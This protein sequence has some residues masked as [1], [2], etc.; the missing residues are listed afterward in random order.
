MKH[1]VLHAP[2][3]TEKSLANAQNRNAFTFFV[4]VRAPKTQIADVVEKT[5]G[6]DVVS[7]HTTMLP[8]KVKRTGKKRLPVNTGRRKKAVVI[9]KE[10]QRIPAFEFGNPEQQ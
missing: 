5:F 4:D 8:G 7:V 2:V 3:V 6:V 9:L 1:F 10:G